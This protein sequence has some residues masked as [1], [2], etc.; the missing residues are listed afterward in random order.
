MQDAQLDLFESSAP[1]TS[2]PD[3]RNSPAAPA[4]AP[5]RSPGERKRRTPV[6][7]SLIWRSLYAGAR[8][9]QAVAGRDTAPEP[10]VLEIARAIREGVEKLEP[11]AIKDALA[12]E[13]GIT[14]EV[15]DLVA[16]ECR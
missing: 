10:Q 4:Q 6:A 1:P 8:E 14:R 3:S 11:E 5:S 9:R 15:V 13:L 16:L 12:V 2:L 7:A